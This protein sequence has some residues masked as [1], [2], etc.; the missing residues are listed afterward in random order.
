MQF[1]SLPHALGQV[2]ALPEQR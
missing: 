1:A 2:A